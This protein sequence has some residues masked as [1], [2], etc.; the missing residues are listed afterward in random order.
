MEA[1]SWLFCVMIYFTWY[2]PIGE[3]AKAN[4]TG[5]SIFQRIDD[6]L[7]WMEKLVP[8][9]PA[10]I[11]PY[12]AVYGMPLAYLL[13]L[14]HTHGLDIGKVR[15]FFITQM[16]LITV[17]F[18]FYLLCPVRT[19]LLFNAETG[20]HEYGAE[21]W[22]GRLCWKHIHQ[23]ISLYVACPSMHT[24]HAFSIAA[25]F[26]HEK[27]SGSKAAWALA[28]VTLFS[29]TMCKAHPPPH[30]LFGL[31]V[32]YAGQ[33]LVFDPLTQ[34]LS[35]LQPKTDSWQRFYFAAMAPMFFIVAGEYL[36]N[37]SGWNTDIPAMFGFEANPVLGLY[38]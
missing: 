4:D 32:A 18:A 8:H 25:A 24:A 13:S 23:G 27:L 12:V 38:G 1:T 20:K 2:N 19:D 31:L 16:A 33:K 17:A 26:S 37:I 30:L 6:E 11:F 3:L 36:H 10:M 7:A 29:T 15:R 21:T 28:V 5:D 9:V 34:R 14:C 22:I 35:S